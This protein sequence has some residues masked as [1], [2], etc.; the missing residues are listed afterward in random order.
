MGICWVVHPS[1]DSSDHQDYYI[2]SRESRT[3]PSFSH[4][5]WEGATSNIYGNLQLVKLRT[6]DAES[7]LFEKTVFL[8][9][10]CFNIFQHTFFMKTYFSSEQVGFFRILGKC[11]SENQGGIAFPGFFFST[12]VA[13]WYPKMAPPKMSI[14][15]VFTSTQ[16]QDIFR[17]M[18]AGSQIDL[19]ENYL[20]LQDIILHLVGIFRAFTAIVV[21]FLFVNSFCLPLCLVMFPLL[22]FFGLGTRIPQT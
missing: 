14:F 20:H 4:C 2:F 19:V 11:L 15:V 1:Q 18:L 3:K 7:I 13:V 6:T 22:F 5:Y 8:D 17:G 21:K 9:P 12:E 10:F 16:S